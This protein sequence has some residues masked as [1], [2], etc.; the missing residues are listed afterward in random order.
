E[1]RQVRAAPLARAL[2]AVRRELERE[3]LRV[4]LERGRI[5]AREAQEVDRAFTAER[6]RQV[7]DR[8]PALVRQR[9]R[10]LPQRGRE[11]LE[12]ARGRGEDLVPALV[13]VRGVGPHALGVE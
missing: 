7:V 9:L 1:P 2:R 3:A 12:L 13:L 4:A 10:A 8:D 6:G 11:E 5:V